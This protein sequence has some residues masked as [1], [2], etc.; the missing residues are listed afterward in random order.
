MIGIRKLR[1]YRLNLFACFWKIYVYLNAR[2]LWNINLGK[3]CVFNGNTIFHRNRGS[4]IN[5]GINCRFISEAN[6]FNLIGINRPCIIATHSPEAR[7]DIGNNNGFSGTVIGAFKYIK[8]GNDVKC[9]ANTLITDS[10]WHTDDIRSGEPIE[11]IIGDNVWLGVNVVVLK[12]VTIGDN[13]V[14]GACS[15]VTKSIPA[16]VIAAGNPCRVIKSI[17]NG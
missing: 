13:S 7:I 17:N 9:G 15:V 6:N 12:G 11:V 10:D 1:Y 3:N 8:I 4:I 16:N 14:I 2:L 5:I